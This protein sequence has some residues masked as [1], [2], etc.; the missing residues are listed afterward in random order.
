MLNKLRFAAIICLATI[1]LAGCSESEAYEDEYAFSDEAGEFDEDAAREA[2]RAELA[3]GTYEDAGS[4][5]G[6]TDDCSGHNAGWEYAA[7]GND[8][9]GQSNSQSFDEGQIAY[10]EAVE[11]RVEEMQDEYEAGDTSYEDY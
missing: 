1:A 11:E 5:Y 2:A 10:E 9:G 7:N 4:P 8:D 6:C 3:S